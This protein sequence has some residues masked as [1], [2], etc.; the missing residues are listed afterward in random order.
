MFTVPH[1]LV[2]LKWTEKQEPKIDYKKDW[3]CFILE[4]GVTV[5][6]V[7]IIAVTKFY[8]IKIHNH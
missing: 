4:I 8:L 2:C 6:V 1:E 5:V 7:L 3:Q